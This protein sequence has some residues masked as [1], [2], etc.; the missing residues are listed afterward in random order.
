MP[1]VLNRP[2]AGELQSVSQSL[3]QGNFNA[4][5][6]SFNVEHYAFADVTANNGFHNTVT[7]PQIIGAAHPTTT[8]NPIIYAMQDSANIGILQYSRGPVFNAY[9]PA[10]TPITELHSN[11]AV[12]IV[13]H[14]QQHRLF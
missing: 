9:V 11:S 8:T 13:W 14:H 10:P 7:Q 1:Y 4:A 6:T 12:P 3:I 2:T 5:N